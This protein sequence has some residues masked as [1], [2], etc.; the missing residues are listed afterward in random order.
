MTVDS[1]IQDVRSGNVQPTYVIHGDEPFF[2]D[3]IVKVLENEVLDEAAKGF[4]FQVLY[5]KEV[6]AQTL[7]DTLRN[8]PFMSPKQ[9]VVLKEAQSFSKLEA[10]FEKLN[11]AIYLDSVILTTHTH[12]SD[13]DSYTRQVGRVVNSKMTSKVHRGSFLKPYSL[14]S[15]QLFCMF[16]AW[17]MRIPCDSVLI[18]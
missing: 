14:Q 10:L 9:M 5:G 4:D 2:I 11:L 15:W 12:C 6:D 18:P 13:E 8:F 16:C 17:S 3:Q 7:V 1:I